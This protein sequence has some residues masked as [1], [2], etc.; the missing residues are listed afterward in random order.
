MP[1]HTETN[2]LGNLESIVYT[3]DIDFSKPFNI[4][5]SRYNLVKSEDWKFARDIGFLFSL[6]RKLVLWDWNM[7]LG[8]DAER[9]RVVL[10]IL[11]NSP[12]LKNLTVRINYNA[13]I[14]DCKRLFSE[15]E[16]VERNGFLP[17]ATIG[18]LSTFSTGI[19]GLTRSDYYNPFTG[20]VVGY[21][22]VESIFAHEVGHNKDFKRFDRDWIYG[23]SRVIPPVMLYQEGAA[24][25]YAKNDF[26][27]K[28]D[29]NQ[30]YRYLLPCFLTYVLSSYKTIKKIV[31]RKKK[32]TK[33]RTTQYLKS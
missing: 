2:K 4:K 16:L 27:S 31:H 30:L 23:L 9:S 29:S 25:I 10:S 19:L 15:K 11:E 17:R 24:S 20:T 6:P 33:S 3:K 14:Q 26:L 28:D 1:C 7:G 21:S 12:E 13:A 5:T 18:L 32:K 8:L 22:N